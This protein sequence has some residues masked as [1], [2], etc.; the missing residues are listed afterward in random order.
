MRLRG[1]IECCELTLTY[2][3]KIVS[4]RFDIPLGEGAYGNEIE[5][6]MVSEKVDGISSDGGGT[7]L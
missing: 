3:V 1:E 2:L 4:H 5:K 7:W 6:L